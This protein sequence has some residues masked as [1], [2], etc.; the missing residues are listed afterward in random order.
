MEYAAVAYVM[1]GLTIATLG[2][3]NSKTKVHFGFSIVAHLVL[4]IAWPWFVW[5]GLMK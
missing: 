4:A 1:I 3:L 5:K 2:E